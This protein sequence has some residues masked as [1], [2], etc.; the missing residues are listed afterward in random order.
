MDNRVYRQMYNVENTHWWFVARK[1][2]LL[3][4]LD[5]RLPLPPVTRLLDVGCG[6]GA[7]LEAF[8]GR[9]QAFGTD[10]APQ[11]IEFCKA[12]GLTRLHLGTLDAYPT[13]ESFDLITMLD[14]VEH[15]EDDRALLRAAH[16]LLGNSGHILI[17]VP[18][19]PSLWNAHDEMLHHKRRYTRGTLRRL[20][21]ESGFMVEHLTF[22]NCFLFPV[23]W[24]RRM[25]A[26]AT[27]AEMNDLE[28]PPGPLNAA[29]RET[30]RLER[31]ILPHGSLPVGLSL[32]CLARRGAQA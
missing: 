8:S 3:R 23:A 28:I 5:V 25:A 15:V 32:L 7:I 20:V 1:E 14:V 11:A 29:L 21:T 27:G 16:G 22:F 26:R 30:F 10:T 2:I 18:A 6:T 12:R 9:Y 24:A 4:Y 19:F 17:A 13:S 31:W